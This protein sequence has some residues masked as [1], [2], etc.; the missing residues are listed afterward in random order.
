M[1]LRKGKN[2]RNNKTTKLEDLE[3]SFLKTKGFRYDYVT[4]K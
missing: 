3:A 4:L 1:L 2:G